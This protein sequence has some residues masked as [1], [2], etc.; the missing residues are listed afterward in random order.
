MGTTT[1]PTPTKT[2]PRGLAP[3]PPAAETDALSGVTPTSAASA[4]E[5]RYARSDTPVTPI[6]AEAIAPLASSVTTAAMPAMA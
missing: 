5:A 3:P 2:P 1:L 4:A 6:F